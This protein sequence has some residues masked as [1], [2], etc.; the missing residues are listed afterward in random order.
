M[1]EMD[2]V[3]DPVQVSNIIIIFSFLIQHF[4]SFF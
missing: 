3:V 2:G 4:F 1:E